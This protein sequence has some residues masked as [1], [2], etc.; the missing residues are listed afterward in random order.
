[1]PAAVD[2]DRLYR[3]GRLGDAIAALNEALRDDP[4]DIAKRTFL[5]ELLCFSGAFDRARKQLE[6][7]GAS[8][9]E[10]GLSTAW[11]V[12][13]LGA[14]EEVAQELRRSADLPRARELV[15]ARAAA[16]KPLSAG[17]SP[18]L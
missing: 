1:M 7:I 11:Y 13:A 14:P 12:E 18:S 3:E 17:L 2:A 4:T 9:P 10:L 8:D 5:F 16:Q 6:A 15:A